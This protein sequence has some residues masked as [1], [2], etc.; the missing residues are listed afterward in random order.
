MPWIAASLAGRHAWWVDVLASVLALVAAQAVVLTVVTV[1]DNRQ[2]DVSLDPI[3]AVAV[4]GATIDSSDL[5]ELPALSIALQGEVSGL[6][7]GA[8]VDLALSMTNPTRLEVLVDTVD[9]TVGQ[10]DSLGCPTEAL[11]IGDARSTARASIP[12]N[13]LLE[14]EATT[15]VAIRLALSSTAP[16]ACQGAVFPLT[17]RSAGWLQ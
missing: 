8:V 17:Y 9:V 12:V 16:Q 14:A 6:Y 10:P 13:V 3:D 15:E 1:I 11:L 5:S 2:G 7:P 4:F